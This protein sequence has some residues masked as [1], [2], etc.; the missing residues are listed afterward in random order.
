MFACQF[1]GMQQCLNSFTSLAALLQITAAT[2]AH[3]D[4]SIL[5]ELS[6][7]P[8]IFWAALW[9]MLS[10]AL[11]VWTVRKTWEPIRMKA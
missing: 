1:L 5:Y 9:S 2:E 3:S 11:V 6:G 8:A 7:V 10:L 4:A